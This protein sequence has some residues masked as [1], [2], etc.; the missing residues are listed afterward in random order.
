MAMFSQIAAAMRESGMPF[1]PPE[2]F[3]M[4]EPP[5]STGY[6]FLIGHSEGSA[7]DVM[8]L[9]QTDEWWLV[10][11]KAMED[12]GPYGSDEEEEDNEYDYTGSIVRF[13]DRQQVDGKTVSVKLGLIGAGVQADYRGSCS[14]SGTAEMLYRALLTACL[15]PLQRGMGMPG[16]ASF[17]HGRVDK[18]MKRMRQPRRPSVVLLP[19]ERLVRA[20]APALLRL[21]IE[22]RV[23]S[24]RLARVASA[25]LWTS[26][27]TD[28]GEF[29]IPPDGGRVRE[30]ADE[31]A[32]EEEEAQ[33]EE[34]E[35][36][37]DEGEGED[38]GE[39]CDHGLTRLPP[40]APPTGAARFSARSSPLLRFSVGQVPH[41]IH[42]GSNRIRAQLSPLFGASRCGLRTC[43]TPPPM[44]GGGVQSR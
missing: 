19:T 41:G 38:G 31:E 34:G 40:E 11:T 29:A 8:A 17:G 10:V 2:D 20:C 3:V 4:P 9:R 23:A 30:E 28:D 15:Q 13:L 16:P 1:A 22:V 7:V 5:G 44:A 42:A 36:D 39:A 37:G 26:Q 6:D 25:S 35:G 32:D 12:I 33:E 18:M 27:A 21:G 43:G 24:R 14:I